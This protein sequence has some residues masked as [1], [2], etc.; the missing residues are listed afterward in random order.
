M[1]AFPAF[2]NRGGPDF[3]TPPARR[4]I[5]TSIQVPDVDDVLEDG[6]ATQTP[7]F[8]SAERGEE[9]QVSEVPPVY[10]GGARL[11]N[12]GNT[13]SSGMTVEI[14]LKDVGPREVNP[15]KGLKHGKSQGQ[16]FQLWVGPYADL[17]ELSQI[18]ELDSVYAGEAQL[19]YYGDTCTKGV[20]VKVMIDSGP[21][22][23]D[24]KHP[25][26]GMPTGPMEGMDLFVRFVAIDDQEQPISKKHA[27]RTAPLHQQSEVKQAHTFSRDEEFVNFLHARLERLV[28]DKRPD[29]DLADNPKAWALDVVRLHLG[30]ESI[31]LLGKEDVD[32]IEPRRRWKQ[33]ASEYLQS[34]EY[35]SRLY[36]L[37]R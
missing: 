26:E 17:L 36:F 21:D 31:G 33:L 20:T 37:R 35:H 34:P 18:D 9:A 5:Q 7:V 2:L 4:A 27:P 32:A 28:G 14:M 24:G 22:G 11:I 23:V 3:T 29:I 1:S 6:H 25:F 30:I 8:H 19:I 16:R 12:W 13:A 15:F 10:L